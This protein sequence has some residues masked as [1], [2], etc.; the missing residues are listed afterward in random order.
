MPL[1]DTTYFYGPLQIAQLEQPAVQA[2][3]AQYIATYEPEILN[4]I[5]GS[6]LYAEYAT[7]I[8]TDV[9]IYVSIRD[10][11]TFLDSKFHTVYWPGLV[12]PTI[13]NSLIAK[14]VYYMYMQD[15]KTVTTGTGEKVLKAQN[16]VDTTPY[17]KMRRAYNSMVDDAFILLSYLRANSII[18][19]SFNKYYIHPALSYINPIL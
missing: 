4:I 14:Y 7:G 19:P 3:L 18:Y 9:A 15:H 11:A 6:A 8:I 10:G 5:L 2:D 17:N 1:I 13:K 16:A 12:Q